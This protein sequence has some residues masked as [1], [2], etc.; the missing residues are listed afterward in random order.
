MTD[1]KQIVNHFVYG[2]GKPGPLLT[3]LESLKKK[4]NQT[5][6][7]RLQAEKRMHEVAHYLPMMIIVFGENGEVRFWNR[8]CERVTGYSQEEI[9]AADRPLE[10]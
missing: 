7:A 9:M 2:K 3:D 10:L 4:V 8:E 5:E 6:E 1:D